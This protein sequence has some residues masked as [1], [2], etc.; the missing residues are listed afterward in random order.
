MVLNDFVTELKKRMKEDGTKQKIIAEELGVTKEAVNLAIN[1]GR[2]NPRFVR[3]AEIC[4]Y[5]VYVKIVKRED[6]DKVF[7]E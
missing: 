2:V 3:I 1:S 5:D 7:G 4:G 6:A